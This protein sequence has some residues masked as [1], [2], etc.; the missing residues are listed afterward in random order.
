MEKYA[1][2]LDKALAK[3]TA[4]AE[5]IREALKREPARTMLQS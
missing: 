5:E 3:G 2:N 1:A 4:G